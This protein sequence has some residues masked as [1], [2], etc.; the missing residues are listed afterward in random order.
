[1]KILFF[2]NSSWNL[3][4][5]RI[6]LIKGLLR[7]NHQIYFISENDSWTK[8]LVDIGCQRVNVNFSATSTS[9]KDNLISFISFYRELTI[10]NPDIVMSYTIKANLYAGV[11]SRY[12]K[13]KHITNITG[14]G[15]IFLSGNIKKFILFKVLVFALKES[16]RFIFQNKDDQE[17]FFDKGI[18]TVT[19][20]KVIPGSG[21]DLSIFFPKKI[22]K[23]KKFT[24]LMPSRLIFDKGIREFILASE[25]IYKSYKHASFIIVGGTSKGNPSSIPDD[26]LKD[27]KRSYSFIEFKEF[28]ED[29]VTEYRN[30]DVVV[31]PSYREGFSKCLSEASAMA[32]PLIAS[33]VPGCSDLIV[34]NRNGYLV[35]PKSISS[36]HYAM[37]RL[38]DLDKVEIDKMGKFSRD[39]ALKRYDQT[40]I[41]GQTM[42]I[43]YNLNKN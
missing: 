41:V 6:N 3:W 11:L 19:N 8:E 37:K 15:S 18:A 25:L 21:V 22:R 28:T 16:H 17:L 42:K 7:E 2:A 43:I 10:L 39:L 13:I 40:L 27:W 38:I 9:L 32:K 5:F 36:L 4:N 30:A 14:L 12:S 31:L 35:K 33:N 1:M 29:I 20:S 23:N 34:D 24:F 26:V